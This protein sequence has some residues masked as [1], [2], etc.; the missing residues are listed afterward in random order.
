MSNEQKHLTVR[1][2][3]PSGPPAL[4]ER[5]AYYQAAPQSEPESADTAIPFAHY[6]WMISR[7]KWRLL[8]FVAIAVGAT[9]M[10]FAQSNPP[11]PSEPAPDNGMMDHGKMGRGHAPILARQS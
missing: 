5:I 3:E 9:T 7:H 10:V 2:P 11:S 4:I 6:R 1:P 8:L